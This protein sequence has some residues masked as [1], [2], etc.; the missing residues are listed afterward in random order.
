MKKTI[1]YNGKEYEIEGYWRGKIPVVK[2]EGVPEDFEGMPI[3]RII[4]YMDAHPEN[5]LFMLYPYQVKKLKAQGLLQGDEP[6]ATLK[7]LKYF[8]TVKDV[9]HARE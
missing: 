5:E 1:N 6:I 4:E 8:S 3:Q 7:N 2:Q 9:F